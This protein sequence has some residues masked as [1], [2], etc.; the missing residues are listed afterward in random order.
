VS[1]LVATAMIRGKLVHMLRKYELTIAHARGIDAAHA[2]S[3]STIMDALRPTA[4]CL[5][6][7]LVLQDDLVRRGIGSWRASRASAELLAF[8]FACCDHEILCGRLPGFSLMP[9]RPP[10]SFPPSLPL[11]L[12]PFLPTLTLSISSFRPPSTLFHLLL[13][14]RPRPSCIP[15][16]PCLFLFAGPEF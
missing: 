1:A 14:S 6:V 11:P 5:R 7:Q 13:P 9:A 8:L 4:L 16:H 2:A 10:S 12:L 3:L 15:A